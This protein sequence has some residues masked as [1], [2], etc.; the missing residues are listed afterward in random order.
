M[1]YEGVTISD[2]EVVNLEKLLE[3][4]IS[5]NAFDK[6]SGLKTKD[7]RIELNYPKNRYYIFTKS[8]KLNFT[9]GYYNKKQKFL[10]WGNKLFHPSEIS[11]L[12][13]SITL[14]LE[15]AMKNP[16]I[17]SIIKNKLGTSDISNQFTTLPDID[18]YNSLIKSLNARGYL[19]DFSPIQWVGFC[20][21]YWIKNLQKVK[22]FLKHIKEVKVLKN[23]KSFGDTIKN[24]ENK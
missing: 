10:K 16:V 15:E 12:F 1:K 4:L 2:L 7:I 22:G 23:L 18:L 14:K 19:Q 21:I 9:S 24:F 17:K 3:L 5:K 20:K 13:K 6:K 11:K 8:E